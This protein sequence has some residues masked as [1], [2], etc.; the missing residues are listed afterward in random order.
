MHKIAQRSH[1]LQFTHFPDKTWSPIDLRKADTG[2]YEY[3]WLKPAGVN[4]KG[5]KP[6]ERV[7][8]LVDVP[9]R[10]SL[11]LTVQGPN[12]TTIRA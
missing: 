11:G 12:G 7:I 5:R 10:G 9:S 1:K 2:R 4:G 6:I 8:V 3:I